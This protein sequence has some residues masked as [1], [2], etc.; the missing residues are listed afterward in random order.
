M[1]ATS[2]LGMLLVLAKILKKTAD[3]ETKW[4]SLEVPNSTRQHDRVGG[5]PSLDSRLLVFTYIFRATAC[6][7]GTY[8]LRKYIPAIQTHGMLS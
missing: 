3:D 7:M 1:A 6:C 4:Q 8:D 5:Q 2:P